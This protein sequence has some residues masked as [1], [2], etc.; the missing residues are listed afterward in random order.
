[1][2]SIL[3]QTD[4]AVIAKSQFE[5]L[6][7]AKGADA[8]LIARHIN[9]HVDEL[10]K[11]KPEDDLKAM[12]YYSRLL[13]AGRSKMTKQ[14]LRIIEIVKDMVQRNQI[15]FVATYNELY[16]KYGFNFFQTEVIREPEEGNTVWTF[17]LA[18]GGKDRH[19]NRI[20]IAP[21]AWVYQVR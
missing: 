16:Y 6:R 15:C 1:M 12:K 7:F 14:D 3:T 8:E 2:K 5:K 9:M 19:G 21:Y 20:T 17:G 11:N 18:T 4:H 10:K 13:A